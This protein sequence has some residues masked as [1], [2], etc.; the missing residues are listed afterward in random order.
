MPVPGS[1]A[2]KIRS[3]TL[4][5]LNL[6]LALRVRRLSSLPLIAYQ[7]PRSRSL[8]EKHRDRCTAYC[9]RII[10]NKGCTTTS[11]KSTPKGVCAHVC[12]K[13]ASGQASRRVVDLLQDS[14]R[15]RDLLGPVAVEA[16]APPVL[17]IE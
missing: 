12:H 8:E 15:F 2:A 16:I 3:L 6:A 10:I 14:C 13:K 4:E 5:P 11:R 17:R 1:S 7:Y 9:K